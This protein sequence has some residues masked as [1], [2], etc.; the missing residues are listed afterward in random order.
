MHDKIGPYDDIAPAHTFPPLWYRY[1]PKKKGTTQMERDERTRQ[2]IAALLE[3][4]PARD[5]AARHK[6]KVETVNAKLYWHS[7]RL[8]WD[9]PSTPGVTF[10][11]RRERIHAGL[12]EQVRAKQKAWK[13]V[14]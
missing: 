2:I 9:E 4:E 3:G 5:I 7:Y 14:P 1:R 6:L 11:E 8:A 12:A 10:S 13:G